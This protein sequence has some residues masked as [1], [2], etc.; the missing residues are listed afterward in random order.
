VGFSKRRP[1]YGGTIS[2]RRLVLPLGTISITKLDTLKRIVT[3]KRPL[4]HLKKTEP[5]RCGGGGYRPYAKNQGNA[6]GGSIGDARPSGRR[7]NHRKGGKN[8][9]VN[10]MCG[11]MRGG[12]LGGGKK[13]VGRSREKGGVNT[14]LSK[15]KKLQKKI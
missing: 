11:N 9:E 4:G 6:R 8:S 12:V 3:E 10:S 14:S 15:R 5:E 13:R 7:V 1:L 2:G